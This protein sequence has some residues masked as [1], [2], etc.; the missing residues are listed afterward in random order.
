MKKTRTNL[1][2]K[3][4]FKKAY[5]AANDI[6]VSTKNLLSFPVD[7][8]KVIEDQTDIKI[9]SSIQCERFNLPLTNLGSESAVIIKYGYNYIIVV[10]QSETVE[11]VNFSMAH[12]YG[13]FELNHN[14]GE[15]NSE[16]YG[17]YEVES[18]FFAA[19]LLMP[20]QVIMEFVKRGRTITPKFLS[21][22]FRVSLPAAEKRIKTLNKVNNNYRGE[23]EKMMDE[24]ILYRFM[25]FIDK[26]CPKPNWQYDLF[27][28]E[29]MQQQR[30]S[31]H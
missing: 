11:R 3:P 29:Y 8:S 20:E 5:I 12:E 23:E 24:Q 4:D 26:V 9:L 27:E 25:P 6:L 28:D 14:I 1:E 31:W 17:I 21:S 2:I 18:N 19:Q 10:N 30:N 13:H 22:T 7:V 15:T 16:I